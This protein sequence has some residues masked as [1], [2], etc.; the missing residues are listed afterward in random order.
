MPK[1]ITN[2]S[3]LVYLYRAKAITFLPELFNEIWTTKAVFDELLTGKNKGYN[4]PIPNNYNWLKK[5]TPKSIP[6]EWLAL[7][8]GLGELE[9]MALAF[10]NKDRVIILDDA[11]ARKI[12]QAAGLEVWGTL[13]VLL[14]AKK[15]GLIKSLSP[16]LELLKESGMWISEEVYLRVLALADEL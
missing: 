3:P 4:V 8:L 5:I 12:A 16:K 9:T 6:S 15:N 14:E 7:D 11:L 10:E 13:K 2:T 1:A